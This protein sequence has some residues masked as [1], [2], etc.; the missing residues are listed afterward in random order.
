MG[1]GGSWLLAVPEMPKGRAACTGL[2][3]CGSRRRCRRHAVRVLPRRL[4]GRSTKALGVCLLQAAAHVG[5][6]QQNPHSSS[7]VQGLRVRSGA[8]EEA[9][10][11]PSCTRLLGHVSCGPCGRPLPPPPPTVPLPARACA[12]GVGGAPSDPDGGGRPRQ[13]AAADHLLLPHPLTA[14]AGHARAQE[15]QLQVRGFGVCGWGVRP[16]PQAGMV[17]G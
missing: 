2:A 7:L 14:A 8:Q 10:C 16:G 4:R 17:R 3:S 15:A 5:N 11:A 9:C 1:R 12:G 6:V 13:R